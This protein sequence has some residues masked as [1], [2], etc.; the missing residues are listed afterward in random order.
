MR[1]RTTDGIRAHCDSRV[2]VTALIEPGLL[3]EIEADAYAGDSNG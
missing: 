1:S 2:E 3:V